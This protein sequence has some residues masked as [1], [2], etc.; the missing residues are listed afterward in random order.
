VA[1]A[2]ASPGRAD[3]GKLSAYLAARAAAADGRTAV[4]ASAY[5]R[6]LAAAPDSPVVA[7]RAY[8][9]ALAAGDLALAARA[10]AVLSAAGVAPGDVPLLALAQAARRGDLAAVD[11]AANKLGKGPLAVLVPSLR[12][13]AALARG[14]DPL[15]LL[16]APANDPITRRFAAETR[17]L[18][19]IARRR[20]ADGVAALG[21]LGPAGAP[22]DV[23]AAAAELLVGMGERALAQT[24]G[25][26]DPVVAAAL[27]GT[28]AKPGVAFG[29][30]RLL[31]RVAAELGTDTRSPLGIALTRAAI[32]ADPGNDCAR[33]LLAASLARAGATDQAL[34][35]L[36]AVGA[37]SPWADAAAAARIA[38]LSAA[39]RGDEALAAARVRAERDG[40]GPADLQIYADLL[41]ARNEPVRAAALYRRVVK[42]SPSWTA[43]LQY[44][45]AL[46]QAGRWHDARSALRKAVALGPDQPLALNYLG[47]ARIEHGEDMRDAVRMLERASALAPANASITDSL[48]WAYYLTGDTSRALPLLERAAMKE[49]DNPEIG[50]HLGDVYWSVG[51]HYEARYAWRAAALTADADAAER[52]ASKI[53]SGLAS[54]RRP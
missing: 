41:T 50:E 3:T 23:R 7:I 54:A 11:A 35:V 18:L 38:I 2:A 24:L 8:R 49:P 29:T 20:A 22:A 19:L 39:D 40:A 36:D 28:G 17:A 21:A 26:D 51:R 45:G 52:L 12:G 32:T 34:A 6:A 48:G 14:E 43:W 10:G 33:L 15:S 53:E 27:A 42:A 1:L 30:S 16:D 13:W 37:A 31:S 47:Y 9:E 46:D 4:A 25:G 44:G 5:A